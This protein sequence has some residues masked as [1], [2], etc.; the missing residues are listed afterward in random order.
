VI[1]RSCRCLHRRCR[2]FVLISI[3]GFKVNLWA[4]VAA[5][6]AHGVFDSIHAQ[7]IPNRG[8]PTWWPGSC[9]TYDVAAAGYLA[10]ILRRSRV[11]ARMPARFEPEIHEAAPDIGTVP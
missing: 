1:G 7:L 5:L 10:W 2:A 6:L 4:V 9:L 11:D 3:Y 8:V